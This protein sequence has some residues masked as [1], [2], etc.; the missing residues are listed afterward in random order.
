MR[1]ATIVEK[2]IRIGEVPDP[3]CGSE[4]LLIQVAAAGMNAADILQKN[5][6]YPPPPGIPLDIP[7]L[8]FSGTVI[9]CGSQVREFSKGDRV[10]GIVGGAAQAELCTIHHSNAIRVPE[11]MEL[12]VAGG[13]CETYL[14]A[15]DALIRQ[16][17]LK[18]GERLLINGAAGGVG[19]S[20]IAIGN[21]VN[22]QIYASARHPQHHEALKSMGALP[23]S[24]ENVEEHGPYDVV[25]ELVG[26]V[27]IQSNLNNLAPDGR[28]SVI[29]IGAGAK[30]EIDLRVL[31]SK[32]AR[33][34]G[35]TLR[36]RSTGAKAQLVHEARQ[37]LMPLASSGKLPVT[38]S[39]IFPLE[40]VAEAYE[41][42]AEP[43]KLGKLIITFP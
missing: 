16:A 3:I 24:P 2:S 28:I 36:Y 39:E 37:Q 41:K 32:R 33:I 38:V 10:M 15:F 13:F 1:A 19:L 43:G 30:S 29:G 11:S 9:E 22:A 21:A 4:E 7:G 40:R 35:S 23:I 6:L 14:T 34:F 18:I 12:T 20:A 27:N 42:F 5:G 17:E 31:M 25:L 26:G 8:E